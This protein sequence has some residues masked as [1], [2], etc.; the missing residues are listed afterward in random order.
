MARPSKYNQQRRE[1]LFNALRTGCSRRTATISA[2]ISED[3]LAR[4]MRHNADFADAKVEEDSGQAVELGP[5][6]NFVVI[7]IVFRVGG[8]AVDATEIAAVSD[9]N[10]EVGDLAAETV[11]KGHL[12]LPKLDASTEKTDSKG[13]KQNRPNPALESSASRKSTDFRRNRSFPIAGGVGVSTLTLSPRVLGTSPL[14]PWVGS[15][16]GRGGRSYSDSVRSPGRRCNATT[17]STQPAGG[18][19]DCDK[20]LRTPST[21]TQS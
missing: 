20:V 4:W 18:V 1:R 3:T 16:L 12:G 13:L 2:G 6:E 9:R 19:R 7:A 15:P 8:T 14:R 21:S 17:W 5:G 10:S 11:V